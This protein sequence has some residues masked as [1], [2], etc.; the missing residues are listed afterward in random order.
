LK[1]YIEDSYKIGISQNGFFHLFGH[2]ARIAGPLMT[3]GCTFV[4]LAGQ[5]FVTLLFAGQTLTKKLKIKFVILVGQTK[6][7]L[8]CYLQ[9]RPKAIC[10]FSLPT[11][12]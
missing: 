6:V 12:Y 10:W 8:H 11:F 7:L 3:P 9:G 4:I 5:S 1:A 2:G